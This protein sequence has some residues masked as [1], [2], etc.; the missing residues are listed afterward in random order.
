MNLEFPELFFHLMEK[1]CL[2]QKPAQR[3]VELNY[4]GGKK[5]GQEEREKGEKGE[6]GGRRGR[7]RR[8]EGETPKLKKLFEPL[9][10]VVSSG[11][12]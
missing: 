4:R 10:Q 5:K 6:N 8:R 7:G 2:S 11:I 3:N 12:K 9:N 1:T